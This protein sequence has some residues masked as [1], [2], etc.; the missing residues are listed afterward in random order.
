M[1]FNHYQPRIIKILSNLREHAPCFIKV[2]QIWRWSGVLLVTVFLICTAQASEDSEDYSS[3]DYSTS[4][5][6]VY[7]E[8]AGQNANGIRRLKV[9]EKNFNADTKTL[10]VLCEC[11]QHGQNTLKF[12]TSDSKA[13]KSVPTFSFLTSKIKIPQDPTEENWFTCVQEYY[14]ACKI[15][16]KVQ[17]TFTCNLSCSQGCKRQVKEIVTGPKQ[18]LDNIDFDVEVVH[19]KSDPGHTTI[20]IKGFVLKEDGAK[21]YP[22][23]FRLNRKILHQL[24]A[25]NA[26]GYQAG[27]IKFEAGKFCQYK[28]CMITQRCPALQDIDWEKLTP[29]YQQLKELQEAWDYTIT[30]PKDERLLPIK[31]YKIEETRVEGVQVAIPMGLYDLVSEENSQ[32]SPYIFVKSDESMWLTRT[33][34]ATYKNQETGIKY[35]FILTQPTDLR[36]HLEPVNFEHQPY[37]ENL[38]EGLYKRRQGQ[39]LEVDKK[40]QR[41]ADQY[42]FECVPEDREKGS[43]KSI[44]LGGGLSIGDS[45]ETLQYAPTEVIT[46]VDLNGLIKTKGD[47]E[48]LKEA[49]PNMIHLRELCLANSTYLVGTEPLLAQLTALERL[50]LRECPLIPSPIITSISEKLGPKVELLTNAKE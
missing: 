32:A 16:E 21:V 22:S 24:I 11:K 47:C 2:S 3:S 12:E 34:N 35:A 30:V 39:W 4:Y 28:L 26:E 7:S 43:Y 20:R 37:R 10:T 5:S 9:L 50:E 44:S 41:P 13:C 46:R 33:T 27:K 38:V 36:L 6:T 14:R 45:L 40:G 48:R 1:F 18:Q 42:S 8:D 25:N 15:F 23:R 19:H 49:L 29:R 17:H 31:A